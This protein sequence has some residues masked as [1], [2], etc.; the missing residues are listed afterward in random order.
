MSAGEEVP[1]EMSYNDM[2]NIKGICFTVPECV[3]YFNVNI[4]ENIIFTVIY[5]DILIL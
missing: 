4:I 3:I 1:K 2:I 5:F